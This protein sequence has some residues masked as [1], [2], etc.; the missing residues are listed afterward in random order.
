MLFGLGIVCFIPIETSH[1]PN[2]TSDNPPLCALNANSP[3]DM[4][5][6]NCF[7]LLQFFQSWV[8]IVFP[9]EFACRSWLVGWLVGGANLKLFYAPRAAA[10]AGGG[11]QNFWPPKFVNCKFIQL[12]CC[13]WLAPLLQGF[14]PFLNF[15]LS[16][17]KI[18]NL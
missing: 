12:A 15:A 7:F 18:I 17:W 8:Q 11:G 9:A 1:F 13:V 5:S 10:A 4:I 2:S 6:R 3:K 14:F 16:S